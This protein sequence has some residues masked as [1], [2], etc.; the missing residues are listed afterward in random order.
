M[1][2]MIQ[3][4]NRATVGIMISILYH[5]NNPIGD[6]NDYNDPKQKSRTVGIMISIL[7]H[8]NDPIGDDNDYNDPIEKSL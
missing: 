1:I 3:N 6:Y 8:Y 5:Y 2:I 4:R 7:Y